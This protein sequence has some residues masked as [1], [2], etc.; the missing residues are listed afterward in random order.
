M[1]TQAVFWWDLP[2][3]GLS[4]VTSIRA[5]R[6][7]PPGKGGV[8]GG[9]NKWA[10]N[11]ARSECAS[12]TPESHCHV[13]PGSLCPALLLGSR[14]IA[15]TILTQQC[16]PHSERFIIVTNPG[17]PSPGLQGVTSLPTGIKD[18]RKSPPV[19]PLSEQVGLRPLLLSRQMSKCSSAHVHGA[20]MSLWPG[21]CPCPQ[22]ALQPGGS[23]L[24]Q[25]PGVMVWADEM[26]T[27]KVISIIIM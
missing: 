23:S 19:W 11:L 25:E 14:R 2:D 3:T 27:P 4:N 8:P 20:L 18:S 21:Q 17:Q 22:G 24:F 16:R 6:G 15:E 10:L 7:W 9:G 13:T 12:K 26:D 5:R 1:G